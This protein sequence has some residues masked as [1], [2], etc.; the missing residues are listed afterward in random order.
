MTGVRLLKLGRLKRRRDDVRAFL[1]SGPPC[2]EPASSPPSSISGTI[3]VS[4]AVSL[5]GLEV[6]VTGLAKEAEEFDFVAVLDRVSELEEEEAAGL[7]SVKERSGGV[8]PVRGYKANH[9]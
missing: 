3:S 5:A 4:E 7:G 8:G 9:S 1:G 6:G 2:L